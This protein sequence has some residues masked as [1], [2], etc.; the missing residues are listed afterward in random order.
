MHK[1]Y[2]L[3]NGFSKAKKVFTAG[4]HV[5]LIIYWNWILTVLHI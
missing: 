4:F 1:E 5:P 2:I 3:L